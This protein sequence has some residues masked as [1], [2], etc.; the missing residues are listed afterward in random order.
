MG[1]IIN[2]YKDPYQTSRIQWKVREFFCVAELGWLKYSI[3]DYKM[4]P[5]PIVVNG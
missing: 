5:G 3:G 4:A 1:N 2:R